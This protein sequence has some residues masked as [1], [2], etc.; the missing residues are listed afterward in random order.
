MVVHDTQD[1]RADRTIA[2]EGMPGILVLGVTAA[3]RPSGTSGESMLLNDVKEDMDAQRY[4]VNEMELYAV[5]L[6]AEGVTM[7]S[8]KPFERYAVSEFDNPLAWRFDETDS[9]VIFDRVEVPWERVFLAG[10]WE[11]SFRALQAQARAVLASMGAAA[12]PA[13]EAADA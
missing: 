4:G 2:I 5:P 3:E 7:W 10:E 6:N 8:R 11:H 9:M 13:R 12:H 1:P